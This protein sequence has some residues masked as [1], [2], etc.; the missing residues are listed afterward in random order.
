M[1]ISWTAPA[2]RGRHRRPGA[3]ARAWKILRDTW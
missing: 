2:A 1:S 3:I